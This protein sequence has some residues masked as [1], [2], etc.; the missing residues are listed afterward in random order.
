MR[1][2]FLLLFSLMLA[3][4]LSAQDHLVPEK[5]YV[6]LDRN[7]FAV[8]ETIWLKGYVENAMPAADASRYLYAELLDEDGKTVLRAKI[9]QGRD[10]FAGHMDLPDSLAS[11]NY[12]FRAYTRWQL[13]WPEHTLFHT[14]VR[15]V[16]LD[17]VFPEAVPAGDAPDISFYP[18][19]G[20][21]FAG[22]QASIG[23]KVMDASGR[24][25]DLS[26]I[27]MNESGMEVTA[28]HT[29]HDGMG[30]LSFT[31]VEG[32]T[33]RFVPD[34]GGAAVA[35]PALSTTGATLQVR[36]V[37]EQL[38][39]KV[40]NRTGA[41]CRL[42]LCDREEESVISEV[43]GLTRTFRLENAALRPG[44]QKLRLSDL[45]GQILSERA[46]FRES[47]ASEAVALSVQSEGESYAPRTLRRVRLK[48]PA[49]V[50]SGDVS[51]SVVRAAFRPFQQEG[52]V[53][54]YMQL[55]S[56]IRG[57]IEK[58]DYYFDPAVPEKDRR[59]ALDL[60]LL[61]QG[62]SYYD[63]VPTQSSG[64]E[65][66]Q[67]LSGEVRGL[68][69]RTP[70]RYVLS[71]MAPALDYSQ[72]AAVSQGG[73]FVVDSLDFRDSTA[74]ILSVT[75]DGTLQHYRARIDPDPLAP[76]PGPRASAWPF[77]GLRR[78]PTQAETDVFPADQF[79]RD[80]IQTLVVQADYVRIKSPFGSAPRTGAKTRDLLQPYDHMN[81]LDYVLMMK[82]SFTSIT[83]ETGETIVR[84]STAYE[85]FGDIAVC[86]NGMVM[87]W[88]IAQTIRI[89]DVEKLS[90]TTRDSDAFLLKADGVVL[91]ELSGPIGK[92][93]E[94]QGNTIVHIPL[95]WQT[96]RD[97]YHPRY[98]RP[99]AWV[100]DMRNTIYWNPSLGL[101]GRATTSFSFY[102]DDQ[103]DGPYFLRVEGRAAGG[104]WIST[105]Q[106]LE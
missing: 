104:R 71:V 41:P 44:M 76:D 48:L 42:S 45:S 54:A 43:A 82:P 50:D 6:H 81:L 95:G 15:I 52:G 17:G 88:D 34:D 75:R 73:R 74:F 3:T 22:E 64:K 47:A 23:F 53:A 94:D 21:Y 9:K 69:H 56:E 67:T 83:A 62:W 39:V 87:N 85:Y 1:K 27:V 80:T 13:N 78:N 61:I 35:L 58:P 25:V 33:Y 93:L 16:G 97:F 105:M 77:G 72:V 12:L 19:G 32:H 31:P 98:D 14:P 103:Q 30:L 99:R 40:I 49:G 38:L 68:T 96:P 10:G 70:R 86:I 102:T 37:G 57:H 106:I 92:S 51:V 29:L 18:E 79:L 8:G 7:C 11:G 36:R 4:L 89:S 100:P 59:S 5:V 2:G 91:V 28:C 55:G 84:N 90:I 66:I 24:S 60:L 101:W 65:L 26:G 63:F 46:V 20:R